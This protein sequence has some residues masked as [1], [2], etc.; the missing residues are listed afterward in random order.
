MKVG[1]HIYIFVCITSFHMGHPIPK[2]KTICGK[3]MCVHVNPYFHPHRLLLPSPL[4]PC[5][6]KTLYFLPLFHPSPIPS[7]PLAPIVAQALSSPL[8]IFLTIQ[9]SPS[10]FPYLQ[11]L[12]PLHTCSPLNQPPLTFLNSMLYIFSHILIHMLNNANDKAI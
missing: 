6:P 12:H 9:I 5:Q 8:S 3:G 1:T 2:I 4:T 7:H 11:S 10:P